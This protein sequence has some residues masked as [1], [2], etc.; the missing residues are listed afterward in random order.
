MVACKHLQLYLSGSPCVFQE[1]S[2]TVS[3]KQ[4]LLDISNSDWDCWLHMEW[5]PRWGSFWMAFPSVSALLFFPAFPLD[6]RNSGLNFEKGWGGS[7]PQLVAIPNLWIWSLLL[8]PFGWAFQLMSSQLC[9]E[10]R[11]LPW[12]QGLSVGYPQFP[13][14][15]CYTPVFNLLTL[16]ISPPS[17][18]TLD[19]APFF[20]SPSLFLPNPF[21]PVPPVII[22]LHY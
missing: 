22:L 15:H 20:F 1:T 5:I 7:N 10:S 13:T 17:P 14:S 3:C 19:P 12:H 11:L 9:P 8:S 2:I 6:R 18:L 21:H 16:C 4:A